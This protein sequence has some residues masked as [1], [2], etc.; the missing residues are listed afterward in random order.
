MSNELHGLTYKDESGKT[1]AHPLY[2]VWHE[3]KKK[4]DMVPVWED[5]VAEFVSW[6]ESMGWEK[7]D[8][9]RRFYV[10]QPYG[11]DNCYVHVKGTALGV[12]KEV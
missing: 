6:A 7:G 5:D 10:H 11:P 2:W 3:K 4:Y 1:V 9:L 8:S 12:I